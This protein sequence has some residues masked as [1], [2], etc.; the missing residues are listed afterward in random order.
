MKGGGLVGWLSPAARGRPATATPPNPQMVSH[1]VGAERVA[2]SL[3]RRP[4]KFLNR[5]RLLRLGSGQAPP[6]V[7]RN[8]AKQSPSRV[9]DCFAP[10]ALAMTV[11]NALSSDKPA[12][13]P[14]RRP[15]SLC[16]LGPAIHASAPWAH[17]RCAI[18]WVAAGSLARPPSGSSPGCAF[19]GA[20]RAPGRRL[21]PCR[22]GS[23]GAQPELA[24]YRCGD[25]AEHAQ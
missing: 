6:P 9:E 4:Q 22:D 15:T 13:V 2:R 7:A 5:R 20:R 16:P 25:W 19:G 17:P 11:W 1:R 23:A 14:P 18:A 12:Q 3:L 8:E 24:A 10:P 21:G